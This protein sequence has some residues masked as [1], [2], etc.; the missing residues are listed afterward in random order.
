MPGTNPP[1]T[2]RNSD[3]MFRF[4][5]IVDADEWQDVQIPY[6]DTRWW[7]LDVYMRAQR[8]SIDVCFARDSPDGDAPFVS[9]LELRPL[10][11]T[12]T[13]TIL[14]NGTG[15]IFIGKGHSNYG[16]PSSGPSH[17]RYPNDTLDR[18]W[19][20][21]N[22]SDSN[23]NSTEAS[24]D[25][26]FV[27]EQLPE[28]ILQTAFTVGPY[29]TLNWTGL[30]VGSKYYVQFYFAEINPLVNASGMRVFN[31]FANV[32]NLT[33]PVDV[34]GQVGANSAFSVPAVVDPDATGSV[35]FNFTPVANS[36]FPPFLAAAE[37]F[38]TRVSN[39]L[40]TS[41]IGK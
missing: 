11:D 39:T 41:S 5:M 40:T 23:L 17:V 15:R 27:A 9:G 8:N 20:S 24:I 21:Y 19:I 32:E 6:G 37:F 22:T 16:V 34:F 25:M 29:F 31:I 2:P 30:E 12:L 33:T 13:T 28:K 36:M 3:G 38:S 35:L 10:P 1:Y 4:K 26:R 18:Y 7:T 14:M